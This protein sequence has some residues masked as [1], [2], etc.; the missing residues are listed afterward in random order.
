[1]TIR[2]GEPWGRQVPR[3]EHVRVVSTDAEL[4]AATAVDGDPILIVG[5]DIR[6]SVGGTGAGGEAA[7][8]VTGA[9]VLEIPIDLLTVTPDDG[10]T[11]R[12]AAHVVVGGGSGALPARFT[13]LLTRRPLTG[14]GELLIVGNADRIGDADLFPRGHPND[15]RFDVLTVAAAMPWR[16]RRAAN[17]RMRTGTHLPHPH[18]TVSR[19]AS[20]EWRWD[21]RR[22][23]SIDGVAHGSTAALA[24][25]ITPDA[26]TVL[27]A[28]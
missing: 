12:A 11:R 16:A 19:A 5:G 14:R 21:T 13:Q 10:I 23:L 6:R 28:P 7:V 27:I 26:A 24:V 9:A 20:A 17:A 1:M 8:P 2:K 18:L 4:A 22:R 3:P 25:T 15:G